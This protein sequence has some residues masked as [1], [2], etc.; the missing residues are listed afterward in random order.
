MNQNETR[1]LW[2]SV[3]SALFAVFLL[4][5]YTQEKSSELMKKFG[6]KQR[7]LVAGTDINDM[8]TLDETM[9]TVIEQPIDF[10]QPSALTNPEDAVGQVAMAPI[11]KGEQ[12]LQSK[13]MKPGPMT[14]LA[15]QVQPTK[16]AVSIPTDDVRGVSRLL[17][18]GDRIDLVAALDIGKG[19][20]LKREVKTI[21][22]D[23]PI[24]ATGL[25]I[26]NELPRL[27]ETAGNQDFIRNL[28]ADTSFTTLTVELDPEEAQ[29]LIYIL[30]T[31]P[32]SLYIALR[33]PSDR[34]KTRM[35]TATIES[36]LGKAA[37]PLLSAPP[38]RMPA[39]LPPP[40]PQAKPA[41]RPKKKGPFID[42]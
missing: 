6:A 9:L 35:P 4:Y 37:K 11:K 26:D 1:T 15:L 12:I 19:A 13:I 36:V 41:Q 33:H 38:P 28:K 24:L 31:S 3:A 14:G 8:E 21:L 42:L 20:D 18:P 5:S 39:A 29:D 30:S 17:K 7:V 16:R 25:K 22:Q 34:T 27:L 10:V 23:I 32:G 40:K 2:I